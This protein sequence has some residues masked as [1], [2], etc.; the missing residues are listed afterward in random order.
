MT[1]KKSLKRAN[2]YIHKLHACV[3]F[4]SRDVFQEI[5]LQSALRQIRNNTKWLVRRVLGRLGRTLAD[6]EFQRSENPNAGSIQ[7]SLRVRPETG[8]DK[9]AHYVLQP[10]KVK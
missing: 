9:T 7:A 3:A 4:V 8:T 6:F 5:I 1:I 10:R 2:F